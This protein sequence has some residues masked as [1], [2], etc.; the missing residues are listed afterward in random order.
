MMESIAHLG[1]ITLLLS[2]SGVSRN[3]LI[4]RD[5]WPNSRV[6]HDYVT[7][8]KRRYHTYAT[9]RPTTCARRGAP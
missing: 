3:T 6:V 1:P 8:A 4:P 9:L 5:L 2:N 7:G